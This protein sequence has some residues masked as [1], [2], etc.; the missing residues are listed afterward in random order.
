MSAR[1]VFN[2]GTHEHISLVPCLSRQEFSN[3]V[4]AARRRRI[5]IDIEIDHSTFRYVSY[6]YLEV[7]GPV[8]ARDHLLRFVAYDYLH[9]QAAGICFR[10][11]TLGS[12]QRNS[13]HCQCQ[14]TSDNAAHI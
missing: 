3:I 4:L 1:A 11:A 9:R 12:T 7:E 5:H 10:C 14:C 8:F 6:R 2:A 13:R